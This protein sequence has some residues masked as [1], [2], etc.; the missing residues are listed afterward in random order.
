[1]LYRRLTLLRE[2]WHYRAEEVRGAFLRDDI[3]TRSAELEQ[4]LA[5]ALAHGRA[6]RLSVEEHESLK[7]GCFTQQCKDI[8]QGTLGL[9]L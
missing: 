6:W 3:R 1:V 7:A 5:S 4:S 8:V 2:Q 9:G